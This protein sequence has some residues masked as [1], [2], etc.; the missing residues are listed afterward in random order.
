MNNQ[1][2]ELIKKPHHRSLRH[3]PMPIQN[4]AAQF[5]PFAALS[6]YEDVIRETARLTQK[7][8][9]LAEDRKAELNACLQTLQPGDPVTVTYFKPDKY[10]QGGASATVRGRLKCIDTVFR[11]LKL[12]DGKQIPLDAITDISG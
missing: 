11:K 2:N 6:G 7:Q 4:R 9:E 1:S 10:K 5:A 8:T 3:L 12:T